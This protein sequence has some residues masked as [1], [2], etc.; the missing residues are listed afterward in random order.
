MIHAFN[1]RGFDALDV[2]QI[3]TI[4]VEI[5]RR[6]LHECGVSWQ[7]TKTWKAS[8]DP[9]FTVKMRRVLDLYDHRPADGASPVWTRSGR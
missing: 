4:S 6:V 9:D 1:E 2:G 5:V 8:T 3:T 7:A